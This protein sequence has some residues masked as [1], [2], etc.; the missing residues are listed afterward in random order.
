VADPFGADLA[1]VTSERT[2]ADARRARSL[3]RKAPA[4]GRAR[5]ALVRIV[6]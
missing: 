3:S 2:V 6:G 5:G 4:T 1:E